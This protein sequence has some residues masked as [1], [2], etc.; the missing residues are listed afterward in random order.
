[1]MLLCVLLRSTMW[2]RRGELEPN[3]TSFKPGQ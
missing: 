1:M 2:R 3:S